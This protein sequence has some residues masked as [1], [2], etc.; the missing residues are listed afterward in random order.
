[1][2]GGHKEV[3]TVGPDHDCIDRLQS[4]LGEIQIVTHHDNGNFWPHS[5]DYRGHDRA[6]QQ[7][8]VVLNHD[9]IHRL[10]HQESQAFMTAGCGQKPIS[11]LLQVEQLVRFPVDAE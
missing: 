1:V 5:L 6:V 11:V 10:Q 2:K 9:R 3:L 7:T 8:Q 4:M